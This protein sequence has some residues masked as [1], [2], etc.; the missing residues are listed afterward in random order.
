MKFI[1]TESQAKHILEIKKSVDKNQLD[2]GFKVQEDYLR[3]LCRRSR[4]SKGP[5]CKLYNLRKFLND[6]LKTELNK[7]IEV[8]FN[9]FGRKH[10]GVLP[11]IIELSLLTP[12]RTVYNLKTIAD[13]I[14]EK[15]FN[16]DITKKQL[17][18][19][20]DL[21]FIPDN[22]NDILRDARIKE[23][24]K[25]ENDFVGNYF[26]AKKTSLSLKYK[27][28][29]NIEDKFIDLVGKSENLN[30]EEYKKFL[31][32]IL[33]CVSDS[34]KD[35]PTLKADVVSKTP[36]YIEED[37]QKVEVFPSGSN[38]E[39]KKMDTNIDSYLSEFF[40]IFKNKENILKK[41]THLLLYNGIIQD[42]F[43][44]VVVNGDNFLEK[45]KNE[46]EGIIYNNYTIIPI[47]YIEFYW[48]NH[49]QK[50]CN[51]EKRLSI[52]FR[53]NPEFKGQIIPTYIFN[54][55]SDILEKK[56]MFVSPKEVKYNIC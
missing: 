22:L 23:Y 27:C 42:I 56:E 40:S 1:I 45:V 39:I 9:F 31:N 10:V 13:F 28:G 33:V 50:N 41:D 53:I 24:T 35:S 12:D 46:L 34:L 48:S 52:R 37:G 4:K 19:L 21:K 26:D 15:V 49:G 25:Y 8:L 32:D 30:P 17:S 36:L 55:N 20:N 3:L 14:D 6:E 18:S 43:K 7:S 16:N 47:K 44:W 51:V 2:L 11:K 5:A 29:D 38:F 54:K